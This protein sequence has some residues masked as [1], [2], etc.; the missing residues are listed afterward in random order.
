MEKPK[1]IEK[2]CKKHGVVRFVLEGRGYYRC[3]KCRSKATMGKRKRYKQKYVDYKGGKCV[4]CGYNKCLGALHFHHS[5]NNKEFAITKGGVIRGWETVKK[6]LDKCILVC[7]NCHAEEH[8]RLLEC[9]LT[10]KP[11][12]C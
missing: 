4:L 7:A 12:D 2:E 9:G 10:G 3:M 5:D 11:Q 1:H 8:E 6:E